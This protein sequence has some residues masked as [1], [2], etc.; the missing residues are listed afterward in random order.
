MITEYRPAEATTRLVSKD[1]PDRQYAFD[2]LG[3]AA[4]FLICLAAIYA[5][6]YIAVSSNDAIAVLAAFGC[7]AV[8]YALLSPSRRAD[9]TSDKMYCIKLGP[10]VWRLY[11]DSDFDTWHGGHNED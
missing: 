10:L 2:L 4:R 8:I 6:I 7:A 5:G 1:I 3:I 11:G 9:T